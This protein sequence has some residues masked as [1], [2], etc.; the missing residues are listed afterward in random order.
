MNFVVDQFR[1]SGRLPE[2]NARSWPQDTGRPLRK[3]Y[4]LSREDRLSGIRR[5]VRP[6]VEEVIVGSEPERVT[7]SRGENRQAST[8]VS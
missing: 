8:C 7:C 4:T 6:I 2:E 1:W 5:K 3:R